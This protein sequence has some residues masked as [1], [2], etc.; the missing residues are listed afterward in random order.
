VSRARK[1][2]G[3]LFPLIFIGVFALGGAVLGELDI[4]DG[5]KSFSLEEIRVTAQLRP[6]GVML[7]RE[8][9]TYD[10]D[11]TFN[12]GTR[13]FDSGPWDVRNMHVYEDGE[14]LDLLVDTPTLVE[15]DISPASGVH[16]YELRYKVVDAVLAW[17]DVVE[18]NW[19]WVGR[20]VPEPVGLHTVT[21]G[22]PGD[23]EGVRAWA[24]GPLSGTIVVD[25]AVVRTAIEDL[26]EFTFLETRVIVPRSRFENPG[27]LP[28]G[29]VGE[30][31]IGGY[32][33]TCDVI[34]EAL[35]ENQAQNPAVT[36]EQIEGYLET[37][38]SCQEAADAGTI[39][40]EPQA[41]RIIAEETA[42]AALA[43]E[44]R[45]AYAKEQQEKEDRR[46]ALALAGP[47]VIALAAL[48]A[49]LIWLKW[50]REPKV[51]DIDYWREVPDDPP[52]VAM[53]LMNWGLVDTDAFSTTVVDLAQRGYL[54]IEETDHDH[55]FTATDKA[56]EGLLDFENKVLK[57]L[58]E[59]GPQTSQKGLTGW[60]KAH[61]TDAAGWLSSFKGQV[62]Q[63]YTGKG[64]QVKG[65]YAGWIL[66]LLIVLLLWGFAGIAI[67]NEAYASGGGAI[68]AGIVL[69]FF[70]ILLR[71]RTHA[72]AQRH[73]EWEGLRRFLKDFSQL[74][75]APSGHMALYERYL[76]AAVALDVADDLIEALQV[77][78]PEVANDPTFATWYVGSR[79]GSRIG[80]FH[81]IGDF[82]SGLSSATAS[83]F[84]PPPS[85][86]SSS[87]GGFSGGFSGGGGGGGGGGGFGA[88]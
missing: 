34:R 84:R 3:F 55:T 76:V 81:S 74:Q 68:G 65:Q 16:T 12:V 43:N 11:G 38:G 70:M 7:V 39:E 62:G 78:I 8:Q 86:S 61:R 2:L 59:D 24:H 71:R 80:S 56:R 4:D 29:R 28:Q 64:Y 57:K 35:E 27:E 77:R 53:A 60:A 44:E 40:T 25:G 88:R 50:G 49:F 13:D 42:L 21:L 72:G 52:A 1:I 31:S 6:N 82:S 63:A 41:P 47:F 26:P 85:S 33:S 51:A 54:V 10:F 87:G 14:E 79:T 19:Q 46:Q 5:Q 17:P 22:V 23:G 20:D 9:V 69:L 30:T 45:E 32:D 73:A 48:A 37:V 75:D 15:W 83:S 58:F 36:D 67:A 18:L 66:Y